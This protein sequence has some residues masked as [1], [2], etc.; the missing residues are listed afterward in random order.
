MRSSVCKT[1]NMKIL[2]IHNNTTKPKLYEK[3]NAVMWTD[4]HI[5]QQ[6]LH[7]HLNS[8][9]DLGSRKPETIDKTLDW[10]LANSEN[11]Q[12]NILDLGCG[13]GLYSEKLAEKG[14]NVTGVDF[15]ANS[16]EYAKKTAKNKKLKINYLQENYLNLDLEENSFDLVILI[17]T[18]FGPLLPDEREQLL[19][20]IK[21][22]LK[23][24]GVFIFDVLN[25]KNIEN[26]I[27]P[28]NWETA[29]EG[30]WKN[31]PYLALSESFV[32]KE[33]KVVLYQHI[34]VDT[35]E[36]LSVYRFWTHFFSHSDLSEILQEHS[37]INLSFYEDVLPKG[38]LWS[39]ENVTFCKAINKK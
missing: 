27:S 4:K 35:Q 18:D 25:D 1:F 3:G 29:S 15:S 33:N 38:D 22:V 39:G 34:V 13:P 32:Y 37:F 7:V 10:I 23:P 26:K 8:E 6:L 36:N 17:F 9:V 14:H 16:I 12:L 2:D 5:S 31:E 19:L 28:K 20:N 21:R 24:N 11:K 30:F